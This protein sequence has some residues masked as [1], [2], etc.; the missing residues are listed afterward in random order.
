M[1]EMDVPYVASKLTMQRM[2]LRGARRGA[3]NQQDAY[4]PILARDAE[5]IPGRYWWW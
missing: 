1:S 5:D 3:S 2:A 4:Q